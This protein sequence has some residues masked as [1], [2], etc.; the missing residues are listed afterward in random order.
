[1]EKK[2]KKGKK[3]RCKCCGYLYDPEK[4]DPSRFVS[5]PGT[6]FEDLPESWTCPHCGANKTTFKEEERGF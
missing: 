6:C 3:Y 2:H 1:M 5:P 4:G